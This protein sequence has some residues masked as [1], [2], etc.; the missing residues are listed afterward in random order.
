MAWRAEQIRRVSEPSFHARCKECQSPAMLERIRGGPESALTLFGPPVSRSAF[1]PQAPGLFSRYRFRLKRGSPL[2]QPATR[3]F[4]RGRST[5]EILTPRFP[6][7]LP[8]HKDL[9]EHISPPTSH[10]TPSLI[11]ALALASH[12]IGRVVFTSVLESDKRKHIP[13]ESLTISSLILDSFEQSR[14]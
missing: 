4:D 3:S 1:G 13:F 14:S 6:R 8:F 2:H 10:S 5:V 12:S 9:L 7:S 11:L